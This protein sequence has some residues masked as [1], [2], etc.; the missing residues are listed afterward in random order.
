MEFNHITFTSFAEFYYD[1]DQNNVCPTSPVGN[2]LLLKGAIHREELY[3]GNKRCIMPAFFWTHRPFSAFEAAA[4][5]CVTSVGEAAEMQSSF[6][7]A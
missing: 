4:I 7:L 3:A 6:I 2:A 5:A 1:I